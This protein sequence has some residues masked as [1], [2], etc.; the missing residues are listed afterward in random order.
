MS[1]SVTP[2]H[3]PRWREKTVSLQ[4]LLKN[5]KV[6]QE[7]LWVCLH[8]EMGFCARS[9]QRTKLI[10]LHMALVPDTELLVQI[11]FLKRDIFL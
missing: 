1:F 6:T 8:F 5:I 7:A 2:T 3:L 10:T 11:L 4:I 9:E